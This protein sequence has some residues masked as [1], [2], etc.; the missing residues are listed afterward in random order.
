MRKFG[1]LIIVG[2]LLASG[3]MAAMAF[4]TASVTNTASFVTVET[5]NALLA[6]EPNVGV[7]HKDKTAY[8][9]DDGK[10]KFNFAA[11]LTTSNPGSPWSGTPSNADYGMQPGSVYVFDNLFKIT[12]NSFDRVRFKIK[13]DGELA[14]FDFMYIGKSTGGLP[15]PAFILDGNGNLVPQKPKLHSNISWYYP[16]NNWNT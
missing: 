1:I 3:V 6:L 10:L 16:G 5:N 15:S 11:G 13:V 2:L 14:D 4:T 7:G 8:I 12:N 9:D